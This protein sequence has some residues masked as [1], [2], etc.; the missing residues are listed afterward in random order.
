MAK[1][2]KSYILLSRYLPIAVF[3][4]AFFIGFSV[5]S[6]LKPAEIPYE[7]EISNLDIQ[8]TVDVYFDEYGV[9]SIFA[10]NDSDMF[11]VAGYVGA[12]DRLFQMAFMTY[13]YKGELSLV[14]NDSLFGEDKFLRTLGF[15]KIAQKS[16]AIIPAQTLQHL[17]DTCFGINAYVETLSPSDYP[18]EFKLLG[19]EKL[20]IFRPLDI[21]ALSTMM[22][23]ELQGGWDSELFFGAV[24][25]QLGPEYL[26]EILPAYDDNFITIAS[27]DVLL[28]SYQDFASDTKKLEKYLKQIETV[29]DLT[30]G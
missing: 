24:N 25:E 22:A 4:T 1:Q 14:L 23:W 13:A 3:I 17:E 19:I 8:D 12:R 15:E 26:N 10:S 5:N 30:H 20:P 2:S 29:M 9:P 7:G 16:L 27:N 21:V 11:K 6:F 28:K 18:L